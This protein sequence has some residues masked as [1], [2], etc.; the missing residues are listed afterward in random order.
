MF[1]RAGLLSLLFLLPVPAHAAQ[2]VVQT[3]RH[4]LRDRRPLSRIDSITRQSERHSERQSGARRAGA[5]HP[6]AGT[7]CLLTASSGETR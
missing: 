6:S 7:P 5:Q 4:P 2:Y 1:V 3:W